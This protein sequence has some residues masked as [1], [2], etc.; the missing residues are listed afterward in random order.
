MNRYSRATPIQ[1]PSFKER[2][3]LKNRPMRNSR[4]HF[5][6]ATYSTLR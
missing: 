6:A 3:T 4:T 5:S 2:I 1:V